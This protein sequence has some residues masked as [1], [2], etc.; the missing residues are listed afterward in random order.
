[1]SRYEWLLFL[2]VTG[3]FAVLATVALYGAVVLGPPQAVGGF[4]RLGN[5]LFSIGAV[6]TLAFGIWLAIDDEQYHPWDG[7]I[8]AAYVL[9]GIAGVVEQR[10]R[11]SLDV[12][13]REEAGDGVRA[14]R[15]MYVVLAA[16]V[17]LFVVLMITKPGA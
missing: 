9:W 17:V 7:W 6:L 4:L 15:T 3:A 14:A 5:V 16:V 11:R 13:T 2:H 10:F 8:I 12:S 1:V